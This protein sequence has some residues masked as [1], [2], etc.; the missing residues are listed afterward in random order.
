MGW[1]CSSALV[2]DWANEQVW[3]TNVWEGFSLP[4]ALGL[5]HRPHHLQPAVSLVHGLGHSTRQRPFFSSV[6]YCK[7]H[8]RPRPRN[9]QV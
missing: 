3:W 7:K 5:V 4:T 1:E 8:R 6:P 2:K 9:A